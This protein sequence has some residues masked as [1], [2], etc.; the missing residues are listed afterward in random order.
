M[1]GFRGT[2]SLLVNSCLSNRDQ[3]VVC[4]EYKSAVIP[5]NAG[6][7]QES[8]LGPLLFNVFMNDIS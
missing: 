6:V 8:V 4:D 7:P 3:C 2:C 1:Y 5:V